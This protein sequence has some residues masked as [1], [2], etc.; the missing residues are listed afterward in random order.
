M[1]SEPVDEETICKA[2]VGDYRDEHVVTLRQSLEFY[3]FYQSQISE[4]DT[5]IQRQMA[6]LDSKVDPALEPPQDS[7]KR[8]PRPNT[9]NP[10]SACDM[11]STALWGW[12]SP[13]FPASM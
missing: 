1:A 6:T 9:T 2:L 13:R 10:D 11:S 12:I 4:L 7:K 5:A 3:K 8:K